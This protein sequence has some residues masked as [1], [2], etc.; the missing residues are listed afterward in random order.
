MK[1]VF[2]A[3]AIFQSELDSVRMVDHLICCTQYRGL[4]KENKLN[5]EQLTGVPDISQYSTPEGLGPMILT[6][7]SFSSNH[8]FSWR[9]VAYTT[10][11]H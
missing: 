2:E 10:S 11:N 7:L 4:L 5:T 1:I 8:P 3:Y 6:M 9:K